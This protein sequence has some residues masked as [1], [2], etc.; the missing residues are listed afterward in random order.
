MDALT[1]RVAARFKEKKKNPNKGGDPIYLYSE[2]QVA[3]RNAEKAKRLEK[4]SGNIGKLRAQVKKD[5]KSADTETRL[6]SLAVSLMLETAE[7]VGNRKS[8]EGDNEDGEPHYGVTTWTKGHTSFSKGKASIAYTGKSGVKHKKTVTD[9]DTVT[10]LKKAYDECDGED[11][12][13]H[14]DLT[15]DANR[16]NTYLKKQGLGISAKDIRG[17]RANDSMRSVLTRIRSKGGKLSQDKKEKEKQLKKEFR[18][19]LE[20]VAAE[21]GHESSTLRSQYLTPGIEDKFLTSGEVMKGMVASIISK[22][23]GMTI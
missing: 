21:L 18:E 20:E 2:R 11:I 5:L 9:K 16:V 10:A 23:L 13:C 8:T 12:F 3:H 6:V 1:L 17:Y 7:R 15:V 19:A 4:L 14:A 22:F